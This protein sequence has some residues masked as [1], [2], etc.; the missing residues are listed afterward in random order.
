MNYKIAF[1]ATVS[2]MAVSGAA[3]AAAP[4]DLAA[5]TY[6]IRTYA[7]EACGFASIAVGAGGSGTVVYTPYNTTTK[8]NGSFESATWQGGKIYFDSAATTAPLGPVTT[9]KTVNKKKVTTTTD[10]VMGPIGTYGVGTNSY[11]IPV[12]DYSG[13][14]AA[15]AAV[16][17]TFTGIAAAKTN[18]LFV[19]AGNPTG[20]YNVVTRSTFLNVAAYGLSCTYTDNEAWIAL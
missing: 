11:G 18:A 20:S 1:A 2:M 6:Q 10:L 12:T 4:A 19:S 16:T 7:T 14:G 3:F 8:A 9:T 15:D 13:T 17:L 5:G